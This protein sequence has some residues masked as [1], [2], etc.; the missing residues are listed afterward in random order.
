MDQ[1]KQNDPKQ[2]QGGQ[3]GSQPK[4]QQGG[5]HQSPGQQ[6]GQ[7]QPGQQRADRDRDPADKSGKQDDKR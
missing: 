1:N 4:H 6:G 5:Q 7:S 3:H 2:Q